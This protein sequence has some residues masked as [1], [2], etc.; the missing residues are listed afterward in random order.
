[1]REIACFYGYNQD[2]EREVALDINEICGINI[3]T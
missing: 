2:I 3:F 1:M